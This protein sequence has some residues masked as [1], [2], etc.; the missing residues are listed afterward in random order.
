MTTMA[1][2]VAARLVQDGTIASLC[3][4][5]VYDHDIRLDGPDA[6]P[7]ITGPYGF[8]LPHIIVDDR[9]RLHP[10][11]GLHVSLL[12][13]MGVVIIAE[14]ST[15]GR[16]ALEQL[17]DRVYLRLHGWQEANTKAR[18]TFD[19]D[20]TGYAADPPPD[21]GAQHV[22]T[23]SYAEILAGVSGEIEQ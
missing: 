17:W 10:P 3:S 5:R 18:F 21:T 19:I 7:E 16:T 8:L 23:F 13:Q 15:S 6:H 4:T 2:H 20:S 12:G 1:T 11:F 14:S 22:M 9:G